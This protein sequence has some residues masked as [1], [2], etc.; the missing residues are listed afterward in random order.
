MH[1]T[2]LACADLMTASRFRADG[3]DVQTVRTA[4]AALDAVGAGEIVAVFVDLDAF[5]DLPRALM[6]R[7]LEPGL[8]VGFA[9]HVDT[10]RLGAARAGG[11][12]A[13]PRGAAISGF[14]RVVE[15]MAASRDADP[16]A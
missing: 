10:D 6:D 4:A 16:H 15:R 1:R 12:R 13:M 3:V 2:L 14:S 7:G 9:P 11:I 8:I 5:P